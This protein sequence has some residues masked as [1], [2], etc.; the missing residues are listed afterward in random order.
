MEK[1]KRE[2]LFK[3]PA[4]T[5]RST[6]PDVVDCLVNDQRNLTFL[7]L[8]IFLSRDYPLAFSVEIPNFFYA[9]CQENFDFWS[10]IDHLS[11]YMAI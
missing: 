6:G 3:F 5:N 4:L 10:K 7:L 1:T 9:Q 8:C 11:K 2:K